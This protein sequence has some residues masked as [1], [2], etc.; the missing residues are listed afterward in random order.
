MAE[1][2]YAWADEPETV[3]VNVNLQ[4]A[5]AASPTNKNNRNKY[6]PSRTGVGVYKASFTDDPGPVYQGI[7]G[8]CFG[9]PTAA[10]VKGW[11]VV[12]GGYTP[13]SGN[14][15]AFVT[16][17]VFNSAFAAAD[18]PATATLT[19]EIGFKQAPKGE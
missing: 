12:D 17:S 14:T 8:F 4:G 1:P 2:F 7:C 5:G 10:N 18:I 13:R 3:G 6:T 11:T 9:D 16:F 15:A 19:L